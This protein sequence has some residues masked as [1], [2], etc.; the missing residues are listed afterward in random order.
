[1][2]KQ[3]DGAFIV[4][5][6]EDIGMFR[7]LSLKGRLS[8][9]L[10]GLTSRGGS[11]FAAVKREFGLKGSRQKVYDQLAAMIEAKMKAREDS[12]LA[13]LPVESDTQ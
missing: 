8:L 3:L 4:T 11:T 13:A 5:G 1:M 9:E 6:K 7:L 2:T 12:R 10:K